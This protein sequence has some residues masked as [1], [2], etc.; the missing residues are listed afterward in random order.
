MLQRSFLFSVSKVSLV[1]MATKERL[2]SLQWL[3]ILSPDLAQKQIRVWI[4][5]AAGNYLLGLIL[6]LVK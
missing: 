5:L 6:N 1:G 2:A 4:Y 3:I